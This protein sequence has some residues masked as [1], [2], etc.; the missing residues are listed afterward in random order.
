MIIRYEVREIVLEGIPPGGDVFFIY[1]ID[2]I[3]GLWVGVG[4]GQGCGGKT[5]G[6]KKT[7]I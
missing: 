6:L 7:Y 2:R 3:L 4:G 5:Q 1:F